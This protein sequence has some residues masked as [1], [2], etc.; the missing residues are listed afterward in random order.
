VF[1]TI[2]N[3]TDTKYVINRGYEMPG[4]TAMVGFKLKF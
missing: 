3:L 1:A 2:D 4:I